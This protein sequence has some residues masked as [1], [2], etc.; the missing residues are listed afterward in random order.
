[1][2]RVKHFFSSLERSGVTGTRRCVMGQ[3]CVGVCVCTRARTHM[4][5][6]DGQG[7]NPPCHPGD[8][9]QHFGQ[10]RAAAFPS[11]AALR[12]QR[13][14]SA[15]SPVP[16]PAAALPQPGH[17]TRCPRQPPNGPPRAN[18]PRAPTASTVTPARP[19]VTPAPAASGRASV[20][21]RALA[22]RRGEARRGLR[23]PEVGRR[24]GGA[25]SGGGERPAGSG[26]RGWAGQGREGTALPEPGADVLRLPG[27]GGAAETSSGEGR[28]R[29]REP[30]A[31]ATISGG[32]SSNSS[33]RGGLRAERGAAASPLRLTD[34][35]AARRGLPAAEAR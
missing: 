33:S 7:Q 16:L 4:Q 12:G 20:A 25:R 32:R 23:A 1:M 29:R 35:A 18:R 6:C 10:V 34:T 14:R 31:A 13:L 24:R 3:Q 2:E 8:L 15:P 5:S 11:P 30:G 27:G 19:T 17:G 28:E 9:P 26:E 21:P 22:L